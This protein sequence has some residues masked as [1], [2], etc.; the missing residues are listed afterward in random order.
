M[1]P[2]GRRQAAA[3]AKLVASCGSLPDMAALLLVGSG[4]TDEIDELSDLDLFVV[5]APHQFASVWESRGKLSATAIWSADSPQSKPAG[6]GG[7]KWLT[8]D[9]VFV[10]ML[11]GEPGQ[12]HLAEPFRLLLRDPAILEQVPRRPPIDRAREFQPDPLAVARAYDDLK[13]AVRNA[14]RSTARFGQ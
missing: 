5:T 2:R 14:K 11:V 3:L 1:W 13:E 4:A 6:P 7:H 9:L 10:E 8:S 12:V